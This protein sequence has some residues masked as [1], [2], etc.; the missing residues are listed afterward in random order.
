[1]DWVWQ[2]LRFAV[3]MLR[4]S[5]GYTA[6]AILILG[7]GIGANTA[8]FT[9]ADALVFHSLN[10]PDLERL[11]VVFGNPVGLP[12]S[13]DGFAPAD[14]DDYQRSSQTLTALSPYWLEGRN[15]TGD[16]DPQ[17][18]SVCRVGARFFETLGAHPLLGRSFADEDEQPGHDR[19]V[20]LSHHVWMDRF[21][22]DPDILRRT[23]QL[24]GATYQVTGVMPAEVRFPADAEMWVPAAFSV[25]EAGSRNTLNVRA[26]ARLKPGVALDAADAEI[27][28][29]AARIAERFPESHAKRSARVG[30][31]REEVSGSETPR[32]TYLTMGAT[33]FVLLI[34]CSNIANLQVARISLRSKEMA[35][36]AALGASRWTLTRQLLAE[37]LITGVL[38]AGA[39][40][41][42]A[43]WSLDLIKMS[44]PAAAER[45][46]PGWANIGINWRVFVLAM[47]TGMICGILSGIAPAFAGSHAYVSGALK[48]S[49]RGVSSGLSRNRLRSAFVVMQVVCA[50]VLLTGAR[51]ATKGVGLINDPAPNL[52]PEQVLNLR[53]ALPPSH[54]PDAAKQLAFQED[55]LRRLRAIDGAQAVGLVRD[56]PYS[57]WSEYVALRI[58]SRPATAPGDRDS[59]QVQAI[60]PGFFEAM[61]LKLLSGR[62]IA[63][64]DGPE[65]GRVAIVSRS[66]ANQYFPGQDPIGR[67]FQFADSTEWIT[68]VGV[69]GDVR[70]NPFDHQIRRVV[71][72]PY[73]QAPS[74]AFNFLLRTSGNPLALAPAARSAVAQVDRNLPLY[75]VGTMRA[76]FDV[77][78]VGL[79]YVVALM[80]ISGALALLL[81]AIG[82]YAVM[83][84]SVTERSREIGVRLALGAQARDVLQ[85]ILTKAMRLTGLG[86]GI[87]LPIAL[88]FS[89][90]LAS[91]FFGVSPFDPETFASGLL[92]LALAGFVACYL[93]ARRASRLDPVRTLRND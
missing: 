82:V 35:V 1:M 73:L 81:S 79:R 59:A 63:E 6:V 32:F 74:R 27:K 2:D 10:L 38:A 77:Q 93:P 45:Q 4:K 52:D 60:S 57:G 3:R 13:Q 30:L 40:I 29:I 89:Y 85:L 66:I 26:I 43:E 9:V 91:L 24:D 34:A 50:F 5:P 23:L 20:I 83:A 37:S 84:H 65:T 8:I 76:T 51:L 36:R 72:L 16:G 49:G 47:A 14:F 61:G 41:I 92:L 70:A 69:C 22:A 87:G 68:I 56:L 33:F 12:R 15:I 42:L 48:E 55:V 62:P 25:A 67:R 44:M 53:V 21:A 90:T 86:L 28:L 39:G 64:S 19:V 78:L 46:L 75:S 11:V 18:M 71:Y 58:D 31:A 17:R 7:L 80:G 54:Y 88:L